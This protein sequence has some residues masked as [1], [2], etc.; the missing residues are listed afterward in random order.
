[1]SNLLI[2]E[3]PG[4]VKT[5]EKYLGKNFKVM[6]SMGHIRDLPKSTFGIDVEHHFEPKYISIRGKSDL[7]RALKKEAQK[8]DMVYLAT[9][10]DREGEP[11]SWHLSTLL[12]LPP[13]KC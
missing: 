11:I 10:P 8:A 9:D 2:I 12:E 4:K 3:S 5:I 6:A 7:I 1:M 13:E